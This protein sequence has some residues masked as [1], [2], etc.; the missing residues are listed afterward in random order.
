MGRVRAQ[1]PL[2]LDSGISDCKYLGNPIVMQQ[3]LKGG[4]D[5]WTCAY[6]ATSPC[7]CLCFFRNFL[8]S[9]HQCTLFLSR[10]VILP[11]LSRGREG[12][13]L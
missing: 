6:R 10:C 9:H 3:P 11:R 5:T 7:L 13:V 4:A 12:R 8:S 2:E 1:G